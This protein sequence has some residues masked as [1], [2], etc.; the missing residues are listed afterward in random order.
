VDPPAGGP[1]VDTVGAGDAFMAG[2]LWSLLSDRADVATALGRA[3][4]VARRTCERVGADPP[5]LEDL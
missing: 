1:V 4:L 2:L 3:A 5:S